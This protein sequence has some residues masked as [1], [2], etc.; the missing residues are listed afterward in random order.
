MKRQNRVAVLN[1]LSTLVLN[2]ISL[3]TAPL[4]SRLLGTSGYGVLSIYNIWVSAVA[5]VFTLQTQG[6]LVNATVEYDGE[7]QKRYQSSVMSL[8][9]LVFAVCTALVLLFIR[10]ISR[11]LGMEWYL[12]MMLLLQ[13][14]GTFSVGFLTTKFIYEFKAGWKMI[15]SVGVT[16]TTLV[17]SLVLVLNLPHE[18]RYLGRI[19]ATCATYAL[20]GIPAC[21][22]ILA[23]GK[24]FFNREYWKFCIVLAIPSVFYNLSDLILGQC[25]RVMLEKMM[26]TAAV[27]KY[28]LALLFAGV[29]FMLFGALNHTWCPY[30]FEDMKLGRRAELKGRTQN[31]LELFTVLS[32]GFLLLSYEVYHLFADSSY[33]EAT[34][35][36][37]I[38]VTSYYI[39]FLCTFPVNYEYYR[40][41]TKSV[42]IVTILATAANLGLNY[43]LILRMD[44]AGAALATAISHGLQLT[45]HFVYTRFFLG[46]S[47]YPFPAKLWAGYALCY[48]AVLL[49]VV[50]TPGAWYIRWPLGAAI[51]VWE[52]L[53]IK[54]RKVLI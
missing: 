22:Y 40:K 35:L 16:V 39:N 37:P 38:F 30:F 9:M 6:T 2:G 5:I 23:K 36:I 53:R 41:Q 11:W 42:A 29:M 18:T 33:W 1:I 19:A 4:F 43:V 13:A 49:L 20:F 51:G 8:S 26:T 28:S 32:A 15:I 21:I 7:G 47:D 17:L 14:F 52:L 10:P 3:I 12:V 44:M 45:L 54:K 46:K 25:D 50:L 48:L 34:S 24:T 31:F 27:G